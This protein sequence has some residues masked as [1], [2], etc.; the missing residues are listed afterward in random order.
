MPGLNEGIGT[1]LGA[2]LGTWLGN[3]IL[4]AKIGGIIGKWTTKF[5]KGTDHNSIYDQY[6]PKLFYAYGAHN[7]GTDFTIN[8]PG[9]MNNG[10]MF[11]CD[12]GIWYHGFGKDI[13]QSEAG[14]IYLR[15]GGDK[16]EAA[17]RKPGER[18]TRLGY[19]SLG[20]VKPEFYDGVSEKDGKI[21][22]NAFLNQTGVFKE[23]ARLS[24]S[25]GDTPDQLGNNPGK[26][27]IQGAGFEMSTM[28]I[29]SLVIVGFVLWKIK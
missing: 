27:S 5:G 22:D 20:I 23:I 28:T 10:G 12:T 2:G 16:I 9:C 15:K 4:G 8:Q 3:P 19:F 17:L 6:S 7:G 25:P 29:L 1:G 24:K 11:D 18:N 21:F 13:E 26:K 14:K